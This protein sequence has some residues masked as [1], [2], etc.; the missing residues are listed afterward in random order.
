M[1]KE[2]IEIY[3]FLKS[4]GYVDKDIGFKSIEL[5]LDVEKLPVIKIEYDLMERNIKA[6]GEGA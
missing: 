4:K 1:N 3:E 6:I 2:T 5:R